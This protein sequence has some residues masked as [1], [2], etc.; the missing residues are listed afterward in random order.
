MSDKSTDLAEDRTDFAEDRTDW[1]EDRTVL[2]NER[3]FAGWMRTAMACIAIA[4]GLR[5]IFGDAD[6]WFHPARI[7]ATLFCGIAVVIVWIAQRKSAA[8]Q[9][10]MNAHATRPIT[11]RS[12]T[13][14]AWLLTLGCLG[15]AALLWII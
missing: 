2:A 12:M 4:L 6:L 11:E 14:L 10:R 9:A 15:T 7:V 1:A 8:T 3:T 5:A 13:L